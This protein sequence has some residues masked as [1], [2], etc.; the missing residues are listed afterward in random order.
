MDANDAAALIAGAVPAPGGPRTSGTAWADLGAGRGTFTEALARLLGAGARVYA[1]DR[2]PSAIAALGRL[3]GRA[4]PAATVVPRRADFADPAGW[5]ALD[6][7]PL[8]GVLL[9]NALHFVP[10][11]DQA[12]V[13]ARIA[14]RIRPGGRLVVAEYE[15]RGPN[16]W[17]PHPV[18]PARLRAILPAGLG[19]PRQVGSRPSA[20]GG[21]IYAAVA[22]RDAA[23]R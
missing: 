20:Y 18:P 9:A 21:S 15:G 23:P 7:P 11:A 17:V 1:V 8:D 2:E 4:G 3:A 13:L 14:A 5:D 6:L 10:A 19:P 16:R 22:E 12:T